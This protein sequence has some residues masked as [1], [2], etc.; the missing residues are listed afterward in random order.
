MVGFLTF[1]FPYMGLSKAAGGGWLG[2]DL[3]AWWDAPD[4]TSTRLSRAS[5]LSLGAF[6]NRANK[7]GSAWS[8]HLSWWDIAVKFSCLS[9]YID[10]IMYTKRL[11][12]FPLL[13]SSS[14]FA[15]SLLEAPL[16]GCI[17]RD[18]Y[19]QCTQCKLFQI[20]YTKVNNPVDTNERGD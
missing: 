5:S 16:D 10:S 7:N 11:D 3:S 8:T 13:V 9:H 20:T 15:W 14:E 12:V 2:P 1:I 19:R 6:S 4:I 17:T 18:D